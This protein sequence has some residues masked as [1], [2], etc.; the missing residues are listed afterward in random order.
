MSARIIPSDD[1]PGA[2]EANCVNFIDKALA[3]EEKDAAG[4]VKGCLDELSRAC[5]ASSGKRFEDLEA[6][7]QDQVLAALET[8]AWEPWPDTAAPS[9]AFFETIRVFTIIGFLAEPRYGGNRNYVG[10]QVAKYPGPRHHRN[11]YTPKQMLGEE[12][13]VAV[14]EERES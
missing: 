8:D 7:E 5:I 13:I 12:P 1:S 14:W 11:G 9:S 6:E 3:N 10:W 4:L 2:L